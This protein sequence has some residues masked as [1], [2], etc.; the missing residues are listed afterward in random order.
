MAT[1]AVDAAIAAAKTFGGS[2]LSVF[3]SLSPDHL[4]QVARPSQV[5]SQPPR[6][7]SHKNG[8]CLLASSVLLPSS[9]AMAMLWQEV[10]SGVYPPSLSWHLQPL[11]LLPLLL[12]QAE[13]KCPVA[14]PE[15]IQPSEGVEPQ[16]LGLQQGYKLGEKRK[17]TVPCPDKDLALQLIPRARPWVS[18]PE[19]VPPD[20]RQRRQ[21]WG[22]GYLW[23]A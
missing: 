7:L 2:V 15:G 16:T 1:V 14:L 12:P 6:G 5:L 9:H 21:G 19:G 17:E 22:A 23:T 4:V 13:T 10:I 11:C 20:P 3:H 18:G 8:G